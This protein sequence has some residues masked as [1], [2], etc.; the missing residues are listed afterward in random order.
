MPIDILSDFK[1]AA[2]KINA[3]KTY[4]DLSTSLKDAEKK[5]ISAL[6]DGITNSVGTLNSLKEFQSKVFRGTPTSMEQLLNL[7]GITKG[8]GNDTANYLKK[9]LIE[10]S[11][12]SEDEIK[13]IIREESFKVLG[14]SQQQTYKGIDAVNQ[15]QSF[16]ES[17]SLLIPIKSIDLFGNL[18][19]SPNDLI[20][21]LFYEA[22]TPSTSVNYIPYGGS[23]PFPLNKEIYNRIQTEGK[24]FLQTY[25]NF[26][27]GKSLQPLM[28]F[29]YIKKDNIDYLGVT[30][31]NRN[32]ANLIVDFIFDYYET[33]KFY[34]SSDVLKN[35]LNII[36][37]AVN[38]EAKIGFGELKT[39]S[40]FNLILNRILGLCFDSREE[41]D[42][43]G[44]AKISEVDNVSDTMFELTEI[45]LKNI[46]E[47]ISNIELG[48]VKFET[49][50]DVSLPIDSNNIL[51]SVL[52]YKETNGSQ[53]IE[54]QIEG[55]NKVIESVAETPEWKIIFP[56]TINLKLSINNEIIKKLP[57]ALV[58]SV[59]TPK[60]LLP[61]YVMLKTLEREAKTD[62]NEV[63][64]DLNN[65]VETQ[66]KLN[67]EV[68]NFVNDSMDFLVKFK[69]F[70]IEVVS[71]I[72]ALYLKTLFNILK[73]DMLNLI[74]SL[75]SDISKS[76]VLKKYAMVLNLS[77][78]LVSI[79]R[80]I[81]DY[82]KCR[83]L[84]EEIRN[85]LNLI[86]TSFINKSVS[87]VGTDP[88]PAVLLPFTQFLPGY[89][90]ER[91]AI[92]IIEQMQKIGLP[93]G[94]LPD[95]SPNLMLQFMIASELGSDKEENENGKVVGIIDPNL[96]FVIRAKKI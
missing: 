7:I 65:L 88:I 11:I 93:T 96:P 81:L 3:Y 76:R 91:A 24:S 49:C 40:K 37:N 89:S 27:K 59:L 6:Q 53:S 80:L 62:A 63:V 92:N 64:N 16:S 2:N 10:A 34:D 12:A 54:E 66:E 29:S 57:L 46:E 26:Y 15:I 22:D 25:G 72:G 45:D 79:G 21:K 70:S 38:I 48:V 73:K 30:L 71:R 60:V 61:I 5:Q 19:Q 82:R 83:S 47:E 4:K 31:L 43:S 58:S 68:N 8:N 51:E 56:D 85:I 74:K 13:K 36:F 28:D 42:V 33:I 32:K 20:G 90:P 78:I 77:L 1:D 67:S 39:Q 86:S 17:N 84:V 50:G 9:K 69:K 35:L 75:I 55:L 23:K 41:I 95:G 94:P 18:K 14:C 87:S 44:T 52:E